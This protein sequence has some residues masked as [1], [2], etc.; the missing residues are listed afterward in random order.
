MKMERIES[1]ET[2]ALKAQSPGDYP[3]TQYGIKVICLTLIRLMHLINARNME[4]ITQELHRGSS[5]Q[6]AIPT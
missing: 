5:T 6:R 1:S 4:H 3:K 2:S